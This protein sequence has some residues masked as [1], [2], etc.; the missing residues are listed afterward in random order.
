MMSEDQHGRAG[1]AVSS[2][3]TVTFGNPGTEAA[4]FQSS[5]LST[6]TFE[7]VLT[8][9]RKEIEGAGLRVLNEIDPQKA[10]QGIGRST[11]G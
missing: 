5:Q 7:D 4:S 3:T 2:A 10:L 8:R 1:T 11:R 6:R 9:L